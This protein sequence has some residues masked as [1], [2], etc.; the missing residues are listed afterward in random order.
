MID[1]GTL[2]GQTSNA[3]AINDQSWIVGNAQ[4]RDGQDHAFLYRDEKMQDLNDLIED[5]G[6]WVIEDAYR[7]SNRS[8]I[9]AVARR[10]G[11]KRAVLISPVEFKV[12]FST[13]TT[14]VIEASPSVK[15]EEQTKRFAEVKNDA[16]L[17]DGEKTLGTASKRTRFEIE[18]VNGEWLLG[19][20]T[21]NGKEVRCWV[22]A[23]NVN[24]NTEE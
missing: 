18:S 10:D 24:Q 7:I 21:I 5:A 3:R 16:P 1:L 13:Q 8:Q 17:R 20:F 6:G 22:E 2:G 12:Q 19:T 11:L 9:A 14:K 23:K 15:S 4:T